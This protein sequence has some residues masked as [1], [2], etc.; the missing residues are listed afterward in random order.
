MC[1]EISQDPRRECAVCG[2]KNPNMVS[3]HVS[4][5]ENIQVPVCRS[6]H[7]KIHLTN[8]YPDLTPDL[9]RAEAKKL[10]FLD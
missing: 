8:Q 7:T 3:H 10:G 9:S 4:Y 6:C 5:K 1:E 2:E